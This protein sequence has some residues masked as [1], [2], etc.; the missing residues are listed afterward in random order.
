[1]FIILPLKRAVDNSFNISCYNLYTDFYNYEMTLPSKKLTLLT[2]A[3]AISLGSILWAL[4]AKPAQK[5]ANQVRSDQTAGAAENLVMISSDASDIDTDKDGLKDWEEALWKTDPKNPDTD[6]DGVK[7]GEER[8][9]SQS[10]Q[11][12]AIRKNSEATAVKPGNQ[13]VTQEFAQQIFSKYMELKKGGTKLDERSMDALAE[14]FIKNNDLLDPTINP[15]TAS[16]FSILKNT[17]TEDIRAYGNNLGK[18]VLAHSSKSGKNEMEVFLSSLQK[19][20]EE[21]I[22]ELDPIIATYKGMVKDMVLM[23]VP[24]AALTDHV[25]LVNSIDQVG[26]TIEGLRKIYSDPLVGVP[27]MYAY[28]DSVDSLTKNFRGMENYFKAQGILFTQSEPG[29]MF[30]L[31]L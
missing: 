9:I 16:N 19:N 10:K 26:R 27:A 25:A 21:M 2:V 22:K 23:K 17:S 20:D 29:K 28:K 11:A 1:M 24:E 31:A 18:I 6:G 12:E 5:S 30:A 8:T 7:D 14:N 15:Y 3:C 4:N 13:N